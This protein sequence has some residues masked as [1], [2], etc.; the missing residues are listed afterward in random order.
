MTVQELRPPLVQAPVTR[1]LMRVAGANITWVMA[2]GAFV[3]LAI[4][5]RPFLTLANMRNILIQTT[6]TSILVLGAS[7]VIMSGGLDI[8]VENTVMFTGAM[9]AWLMCNHPDASGLLVNP[10]LATVAGLALG[11][12]VGLVQAFCILRV[13]MNAWMTSMSVAVIINGLGL[14][15]LNGSTLWPMPEPYRQL[16]LAKIGPVHV[17]IIVVAVLYLFIHTILTQRA[18]GREWYAT[19]ANR[20]AARASAINTDKVMTLA[21]VLSGLGGA[22]A[23]WMWTG[24]MNLIDTTMMNGLTFQ[25]TAA[26]VMGGI[27]LKGGRGNVLQAWSGILLLTLISNGLNL[28]D[29]PPAWVAFARGLLILLAT[30]FDGMRNRSQV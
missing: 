26:A 16:G 24:R 19:G 10:W 3:F 23:G 22:V 2:A 12:L 25:V 17:S 20:R 21:L 9:S 28:N 4:T 1:R 14:I 29:V 8:T 7:V 18:I 6:V 11:I 13:K 27:S 15:L 30:F 5:C